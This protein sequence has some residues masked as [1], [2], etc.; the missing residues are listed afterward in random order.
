MHNT[1]NNSRRFFAGI[2]AITQT[3]LSNR[4]ASYHS[5]AHLTGTLAPRGA[6]CGYRAEYVC[7]FIASDVDITPSA[8]PSLPP[9]RQIEQQ[10]VALRIFRPESGNRYSGTLVDLMVYS[11]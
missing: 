1:Y 9:C 2:C 4:R 3:P 5:A 8:F 11:P 6:V 10:L 7:I